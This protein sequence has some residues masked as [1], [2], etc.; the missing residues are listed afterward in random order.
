MDRF[1]TT[2]EVARILRM[3]IG[4]ARNRLSRGD[5]MSPNMRVG[6][7]CLFPQDTLDR[8]CAGRI[9]ED[10][11]VQRRTVGDRVITFGRRGRPRAR[12]F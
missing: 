9:A 4:T 8:W 2:E 11:G 10:N 7:R 6:R 5:D 12:A 3:S 1:Y